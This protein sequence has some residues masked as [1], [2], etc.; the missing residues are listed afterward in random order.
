MYLI[1]LLFFIVALLISLKLD[2]DEL[3]SPGSLMLL[4]LAISSL[5][6][7]VGLGF[8]NNIQLTSTVVFIM[9]VGVAGILTGQVVARCL[10]TKYNLAGSEIDICLHDRNW[11]YVVL[12]I[13]VLFAIYLRIIETLKIGSSLGIDGLSYSAVAEVVRN[14]TE[15]INSADGMKLGV[16]FSFLERQMEKV[17]SAIGY[18][19]AALIGFRFARAGRVKSTLF[20]FVPLVACCVHVLISGGRGQ[21]IYYCVAVFS[22]Y[23]IYRLRDGVSG[24]RVTRS[25]LAFGGIAACGILVL[26]YLGSFAVGRAASSGL[27][28]Y[29]SFYFGGSIPSLQLLIN[30]SSLLLPPMAPGVRTLYYL[31]AIPF[32]LGFVGSYPSYSLAWVHPGNHASNVYTGFARPYFDF[33]L[34]GMFVLIAIEVVF[35]ITLYRWA[36]SRG[37]LVPVSVFLLFSGY[38]FDFARE[39]FFYSRFLSFNGLASLL[40]IILFALFMSLSFKNIKEI[41]RS[42]SVHKL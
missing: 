6:A 34:L 16:G 23:S 36:K 7:M 17:V 29:L 4:G 15:A 42:A 18:V 30:D 11:K 9:I 25:V 21:I 39:D 5:F 38:I 28:D 1:L 10:N 3:L 40:L 22:S 2:H 20:A 33:G 35:L 19:S 32:K 13:L 31:S 26:F 37:T 27:I 24:K 41:F 12:T 14:A 8:W